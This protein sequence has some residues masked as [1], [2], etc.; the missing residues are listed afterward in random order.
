MPIDSRYRSGL[1]KLGRRFDSQE[2][3]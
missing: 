1:K 3:R 2:R